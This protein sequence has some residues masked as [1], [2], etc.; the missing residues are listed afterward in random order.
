MTQTAR[1]HFLPQC[2]PVCKSC[3]QRDIYGSRPSPT[4]AFLTPTAS[5]SASLPLLAMFPASLCYSSG[6]CVLNPGITLVKWRLWVPSWPVGSSKQQIPATHFF[7]GH[8][9]KPPLNL[10][11]Y[12]RTIACQVLLMPPGH[13]SLPLP[14]ILVPRQECLVCIV[15]RNHKKW[16]DVLGILL[17]FAALTEDQVFKIHPWGYRY[18]ESVHFVAV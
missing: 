14:N 9:I 1:S 4:L 6:C 8:K 2:L 12:R 5:S 13:F 10:P 17:W 15:F 7:L 11:P 3:L 16:S 18:Q